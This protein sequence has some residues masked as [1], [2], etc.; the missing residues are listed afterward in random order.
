MLPGY[1]HN[2]RH[3]GVVFHI[4]TE[5]GGVDNPV[6]VTHVF[7]GGNVL[8][9]R[10]SNYQKFIIKPSLREIVLAI[11]Q[12]QHKE[13]MKDLVHGRL[14]GVQKRLNQ[15]TVSIVPPDALLPPK[16]KAA[17]PRAVVPPPKVA[18]RPYR[19]PGAPA[20]T[21]DTTGATEKTLDEMI[22]EFLATEEPEPS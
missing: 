22:L 6:V 13:M 15:P 12:E 21:L 17:E 3:E 2:L 10:R 18:D 11:M 19:K 4:Q 5:D 20:R 7:A 14:P 16:P 8:A 9:A 1:N